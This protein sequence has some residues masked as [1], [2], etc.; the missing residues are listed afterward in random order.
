MWPTVEPKVSAAMESL[1]GV[2]AVEGYAA[3]NE[4]C[5]HPN[6]GLRSRLRVQILIRALLSLMSSEECRSDS[7]LRP[8]SG[9]RTLRSPR[10][11]ERTAL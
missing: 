2:A 4:V 1:N 10:E 3:L 7:L 8:L 5:S 11:E 9:A 6:C